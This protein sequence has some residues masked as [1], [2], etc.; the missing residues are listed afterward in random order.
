[1]QVRLTNI[2]G[3]RKKG[4]GTFFLLVALGLVNQPGSA[5]AQQ[6]AANAPPSSN[7]ASWVPVALKP[8][9]WTEAPSQIYAGCEQTPHCAVCCDPVYNIPDFLGDFFAR[10]LQ[11]CRIIP[12]VN[13][14]TTQ[15]LTFTGT[16]SDT[17]GQIPAIAGRV[18]I[19][20]VGTF[21]APFSSGGGSNN[22]IGGPGGPYNISSNVTGTFT[23]PTNVTLN[24][25]TELTGLIDAKF[26]GAAFENGTGNLNTGDVLFN[27]LFTTGRV[28]PGAVICVNL[29]DPSNGGAVGRNKFFDDG[30]PIPQDRVY[31][32]Y[33]HVS[34]FRGLGTGFDIN[35]YV[36]GVEKTFLDGLISVEVRVPFAGTANSDQVTGQ[37]LSVDNGEFGN[38]GLA[39][40]AALYR[41][42]HFLVSA[43]LGLSFP[44]CDDSRM[45]LNGQPVIDIQNEAVLLQP[46]F[47]AAWAPNDRMYAQLGLQLDFDPSGNPVQT[48]T[49]TG[50]PYRAGTLRD[51]HYAF[52]SGAAGYWLYKNDASWLTGV[53]LQGELHYDKS[54][55]PHHVV[56]DGNVVVGDLNSEI[57]VLNGTAG[58]IA[59]VGKRGSFALG[60]SFPLTGN[61]VYD[62]NL[63]AQLTYRFGP[64]VP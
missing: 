11:A 38:L 61:H 29:P 24:Q 4:F 34:D 53:A 22:G 35:R 19:A 21:F 63:I 56:Q 9:N 23:V 45:I 41:T 52:L 14:L 5:Q 50:A 12:P 51:Q 8:D 47:G 62:W 37:G 32:L 40:K 18:R 20:I 58:V 2:V 7:D 60:A 57:D 42:P 49:Q 6:G 3:R 48:L 13:T 64:R 59:N 17:S 39:F 36:V 54:F 1:M 10:G 43:G 33:N 26:P 46:L 30:S 15:T 25:N 31:F 55:G 16:A 27:Y 28:I 44:T